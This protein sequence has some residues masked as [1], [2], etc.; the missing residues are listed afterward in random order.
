MKKSHGEEASR[1]GKN[2]EAHGIQSLVIGLEM[3]IWSILME[4]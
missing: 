4:T 2:P 3:K 1:V